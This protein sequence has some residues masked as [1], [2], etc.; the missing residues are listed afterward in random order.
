MT[1]Q[2]NYCMQALWQAG[3]RCYMV[4]GCVRDSILGLQ[5][6]DYDLCTDATPE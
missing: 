6:H 1:Q 4:G 3:Y 2:V 5:P